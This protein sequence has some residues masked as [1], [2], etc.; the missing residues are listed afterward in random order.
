MKYV[1]ILGLAA[2]A[3]MALM[4][5]GA[6]TASASK[7]CKTTVST[8]P[9]A[10]T[11]PSGTAVKSSLKSASAVLEVNGLVEDTCTASTV[12]GSTNTEGS[13]TT[14]V[15]GPISSLTF[16]GCTNTTK[17]ITGGSLEVHSAAGGG[18][19]VTSK[20]AEVTV[21]AF[22][23]ISCIAKTGAGTTIGPLAE[24]ANSTSDTVLT[25]NAT[26]P[27][28]GAG[29]PANALWTAE[30]TVTSPVPLYVSAS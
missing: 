8:C 9:A 28:S 20:G 30:Y 18:G 7:L 22:G 2:F 1:K 16:T 10:W 13:S 15:G 6:G 17:V 12:N 19:T 21:V 11:Y 3:A 23:F 24:P 5:F 26:I 4:A 29:C 25:A 14:T 27:L